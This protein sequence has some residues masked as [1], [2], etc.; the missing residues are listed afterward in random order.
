MPNELQESLNTR[1]RVQVPLQGYNTLRTEI[2]HRGNNVSRLA[3][4]GGALAVCLWS[5]PM[6]ARS[7]IL[8]AIS[9]AVI[10]L[11]RLFSFTSG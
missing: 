10:S 7:W 8:L 5:R 9:T 6:D 3:T 2:I 1:D 11:F 4:V